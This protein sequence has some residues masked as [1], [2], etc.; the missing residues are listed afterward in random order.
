MFYTVFMALFI[1]L[2]GTQWLPNQLQAVMA[3]MVE[4][5]DFCKDVPGTGDIMDVVRSQ[6]DTLAKEVAKYCAERSAS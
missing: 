1:M 6:Q 5:Y 3:N 2:T 4:A